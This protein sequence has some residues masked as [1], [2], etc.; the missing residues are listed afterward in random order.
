[1]IAHKTIVPGIR[2]L[3]FQQIISL[4]QYTCRELDSVGRAPNG[5]ERLAIERDPGDVLDMAEIQEGLRI[6]FGRIAVKACPING[7]ATVVFDPGLLM[8]GPIR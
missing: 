7:D 6:Q 4:L 5:S 2:D 8:G 3:N 1:M